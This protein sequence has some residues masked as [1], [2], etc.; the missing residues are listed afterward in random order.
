MSRKI[1]ANSSRS[2]KTEAVS[3]Y[4]STRVMLRTMAAVLGCFPADVVEGA[5]DTFLSANPALAAVARTALAVANDASTSP[6]T[7]LVSGDNDAS[8]RASR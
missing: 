1:N 5:L 8:Q 4:R 7:E 2:E 6:C 3:L